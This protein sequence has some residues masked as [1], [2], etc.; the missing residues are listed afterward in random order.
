MR[1]PRSARQASRRSPGL[2]Q[3]G[4][5]SPAGGHRPP[6]ARNALSTA[7][8]RSRACQPVVHAGDLACAHGGH[9]GDFAGDPARGVT[10]SRLTRWRSTPSALQSG[11]SRNPLVA[12]TMTMVS[13]ASR[14]QRRQRGRSLDRLD[15][16]LHEHWRARHRPHPRSSLRMASAAKRTYSWMS[17]VPFW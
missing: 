5:T 7:S 9:A 4:R 12:V 13:P 10:G 15:H 11:G 2:R 1:Q 14:C 3:R 8:E 16:L 6:N 17:S